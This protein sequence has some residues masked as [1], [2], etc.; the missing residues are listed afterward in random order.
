MMTAASAYSIENE[1]RLPVSYWAAPGHVMAWDFS[2]RLLNG[3]SWEIV[4]GL[5]WAGDA[6]AE[7][8]HC[9]EFDGRGNSPGDPFSGYNYNTSYIGG[10]QNEADPEPARFTWIADPSATAVFGDAEYAAGANKFMRAPRN[11]GRDGNTSTRAAGT[12]GYRHLG[13]TSVAFADGHVG[14]WEP[15][16]T[17]YDFGPTQRDLQSDR[18][19]FLSAD[20]VLYDLGRRHP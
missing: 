10:G 3:G 15:R 6:P 1:G 14:A 8:Q 11:G 19:G 9:S 13:T 2:R 20:N 16:F 17:I 12:Q 4:P 18:F 7:I 5:L